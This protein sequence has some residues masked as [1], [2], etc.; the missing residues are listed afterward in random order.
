[1]WSVALGKN[2]M[3]VALQFVA[4]DTFEGFYLYLYFEKKK[5][6]NGQEYLYRKKTQI[7]L[8][9]VESHQSQR[10]DPTNFPEGPIPYR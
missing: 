2:S 5:K 1:M 6:D 7:P 3:L 10:Y 9:S 4:S 8:E